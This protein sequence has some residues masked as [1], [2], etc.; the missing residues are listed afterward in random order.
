MPLQCTYRDIMAKTVFIERN[1][2]DFE[3]GLRQH[4]FKASNTGF[5]HC[6]FCAYFSRLTTNVT[7]HIEAKHV[8]KDGF[9]CAMC[10]KVCPTRSSLKTHIYRY[11]PE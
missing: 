3:E 8:K 6:K 10:N 1:F 2:L 5:W 4:M 7:R 9:S 11:H